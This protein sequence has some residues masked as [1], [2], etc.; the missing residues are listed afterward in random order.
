M[1]YGINKVWVRQEKYV[2]FDSPAKQFQRDASRKYQ[3]FIMTGGFAWCWKEQQRYL[4]SLFWH[5]S[6]ELISVLRNLI[7]IEEMERWIMELT[8]IYL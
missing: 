7:F 1:A 2:F 3:Q 5:T 4:L 8:Y 6:S